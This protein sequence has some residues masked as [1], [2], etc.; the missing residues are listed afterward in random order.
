MAK[1]LVHNESPSLGGWFRYHFL[2]RKLATLPGIF[3]LAIL[4]L[5]MSYL[6]V[7]VDYKLGVVVTAGIAGMMVCVLCIAYP[8]LGFY[9]TY[10]ISIFLM[11]PGRLTNSDKV[12]P[13][14]LI[15]EYISYLTLLG[16]VARHHYRKEAGT[17]FW[18]NMITIWLLIG[19][20]FITLEVFNPAMGSKLGWFNFV[21]KQ[22][23]F[24]AFMY[25]SYCFFQTKRSI[26]I[27]TNFWIILTTVEA[28]Y[29]IKQQWFGF[30][31]FEYVWLTSDP[32]RYDLFVNYGF[33]RK[34][35]FLSDPAAAGVLYATSTVFLLVLALRSQ[36]LRK[37]LLYYLLVVLHFL[38]SS[39]TGTRTAT[40]MIVGAAA[41]YCI[42]TLY[43]KRTLIF[44][45]ILAVGLTGLMVAPI[46][47]N[48]IINR[49]RT[50]FQ[51]SK[52]PSAL[53]R[54]FNRQLVH[55]YVYTH[56]IGGGLST[57]GLIGETYN[58]GHY[59]ASIPPDSGYMQTMMEQGP[60]GL[61]L[62][63]IL[64]YIILRKGIKHFYRVRDPDIKTMYATHLV[65]LFSMF[66]AQ[67]SQMAIG[68][69][70]IGL[71]FYSGLAFLMKL[72]TFD[73]S[74][75]KIEETTTF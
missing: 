57:A 35:G 68:Q 64:Y 25:V 73:S 26:Q 48:I 16:I 60:I 4:A 34:F 67:I 61:A 29:C 23:S 5:A 24:I 7:L 15:P 54:D 63:L 37:R 8:F 39:Y 11:F 43:E 51:A 6:V 36:N 33:V 55:S 62:M 18:S 58:P 10:I 66:L 71:Y 44:T 22:F 59:L 13:T 21:R 20:V 2:H 70:P 72:Y 32:K 46:Y 75:N 38:A 30:S 41:F 40:L 52:D 42:L 50:T 74:Y 1:D 31:N 69:Y 56:P 49:I 12:I 9:L 14:G 28:L 27:F 65:C 3:F 19:F 17:R 53:T 45:V 47:D